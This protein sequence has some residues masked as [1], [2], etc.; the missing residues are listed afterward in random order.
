LPPTSEPP[1]AGP[2]RLRLREGEGLGPE[3]E[4]DD[5]LVIGRL[6]TLDGALAGD[7]GISRRH[8]VLRR[9]PDGG[10]VVEDAYSANGTWVNRGRIEGPRRL[11]AGD[12]LQLGATVFVVTTAPA[13]VPDAP[14]SAPPAG[15][16][17]A[18]SLDLDAGEIAIAI[19]GGPT[20][21]IVRDG[22]SWRVDGVA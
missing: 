10:L 14:E 22:D 15:R 6:T 21:R 8:G 19:D 20:T 1:P 11:A 18:V 5:E 9:E 3:L 2:L 13:P 12:E 16:R 4:V 17:V 7:R